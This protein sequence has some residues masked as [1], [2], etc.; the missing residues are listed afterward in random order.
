[1]TGHWADVSQENVDVIRRGLEAFN[2]ED[3]ERIL[4]FVDPDFE[5]EVSG[6]LSA[7]PDTHRGHEAFA[8]TSSPSG[9]PW[10]RSALSQSDRR[11]SW[12]G[13]PPAATR[14]GPGPPCPAVCPLRSALKAAPRERGRGAETYARASGRSTRAPCIAVSGER[15]GRRHRRLTTVGAQRGV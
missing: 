8:V 11:P 9:M 15:T 4:A 14:Q 12:A 5:T 1:M 10:T 2:S 13:R 6:E 7:E 3:M